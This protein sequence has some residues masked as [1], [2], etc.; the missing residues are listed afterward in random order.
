[1]KDFTKGISNHTGP[2]PNRLFNGYAGTSTGDGE[3]TK[4]TKNTKS[5]KS[6][7]NTKSKKPKVGAFSSP[8][9]AIPFIKD[10]TKLLRKR[11]K[12]GTGVL[13]GAGLRKHKD[14]ELVI[15]LGHID[16]NIQSYSRPNSDTFIDLDMNI[17][18]VSLIMR[19]DAESETVIHDGL[20]G[21]LN[22]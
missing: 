18:K 19:V 5:K 2:D 21:N 12:P 13:I 3:N 22:G 17:P 16:V 11:L 10:L 15:G 1:M 6:K 9:E 14:L 20:G 7:K 8:E 4:N